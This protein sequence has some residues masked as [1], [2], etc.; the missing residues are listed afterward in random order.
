[1]V[2]ARVRALGDHERSSQERTQA[3]RSGIH[4]M[5]LLDLLWST[6]GGMQIPGPFLSGVL[7]SRKD[8]DKSCIS[9][10]NPSSCWGHP[11]GSQAWGR[12]SSGGLVG[13]GDLGTKGP[14]ASEFHPL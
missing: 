13:R 10:E 1:M 9:H 14:Q 11:E 2:S 4:L 3:Q 8:H 12:H 7:P 5:G 6:G